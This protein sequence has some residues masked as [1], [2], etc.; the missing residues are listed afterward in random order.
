MLSI[1]ARLEELTPTSSGTVYCSRVL[2][3]V[4]LIFDLNLGGYGDA[5]FCVIATPPNIACALKNAETCDGRDAHMI[6]ALTPFSLTRLLPE[7]KKA[8][9]MFL[10]RLLSLRKPMIWVLSRS[11]SA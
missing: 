1:S 6:G 10:I 4:K 7:P 11:A 8:M 9:T 2:I 5:S 3:V